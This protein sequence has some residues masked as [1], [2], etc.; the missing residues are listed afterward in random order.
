MEMRVEAPFRRGLLCGIALAFCGVLVA[1][2]LLFAAQ[3]SPPVLN[4]QGNLTDDAGNPVT[5]IKIMVFRIYDSPAAPPGVALWESGQLGVEVKKGAFSVNLGEEGQKPIDAEK[6]PPFPAALF[7]EDK[8]YLGVTVDGSELMDRKRL[9]SVPYALNAGSGIP[10]GVIVMWSGNPGNVP[11]GWALCD[12]QN[13]TPDLRDRFIVGTGGGYLVGNTGGSTQINLDSHK[14]NLSSDQFKINSD[15]SHTHAVTGS[16]TGIPSGF[17]FDPRI[18]NN[19]DENYM[20][21][22]HNISGTAQSAGSHTHT[23]DAGNTDDAGSAT[24]D[25]R[26][27]YYALAF[28]MKL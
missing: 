2:P 9:V 13:Q 14:H 21:H 17:N 28:I 27:P 1:A 18:R 11:E 3:G 16:T 6:Q 19:S 15:G 5:G 8:R 24:L 4:Y 22:Q 23:I 20:G 7:L 10:K 26:P 25:N 12:G